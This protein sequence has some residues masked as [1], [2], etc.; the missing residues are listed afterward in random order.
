MFSIFVLGVFFIAALFAGASSAGVTL[1]PRVIGDKYGNDSNDGNEDYVFFG[2]YEHWSGF[3]G[4]AFP[5]DNTYEL[6]ARPILWRVMSADLSSNPRKVI[7]LSH[8]TLDTNKY[9]SGGDSTWL[10]SPMQSFLNSDAS[11]VQT[12][13]RNGADRTPLI[14]GF[15]HESRFSALERSAML[16]PSPDAETNSV[17]TLPSSADVRSGWFESGASGNASRQIGYIGQLSNNVPYWTRSPRVP[18]YAWYV[19][20]DGNLVTYFDVLDA[21]GVRPAFFLNLESL[22]FK[23]GSDLSTPPSG[24]AGEF[25]NPYMLYAASADVPAIS[26]DISV[27]GN[28]LTV[29]F[30]QPVAHAYLDTASADLL[31]AKFT[32]SDDQ[33]QSVA[34]SGVAF[35]SGKLVLTLGKAAAYGGGDFS[36][37]YKAYA[38]TDTDGI[39]LLTDRLAVKSLG[40]GTAQTAVNKTPNPDSGGD[41]DPGMTTVTI[42]GADVASVSVS[43]SGNTVTVGWLEENKPNSTYDLNKNSLTFTYGESRFT[44]ALNADEEL[45]VTGDGV[46]LPDGTI[47]VLTATNT[48]TTQA[49]EVAENSEASLRRGASY[50]LGEAKT[51]VVNGKSVV[52]FPAEQISKLPAGTYDLTF[53][54]KSGANPAFKGTFAKGYVHAVSEPAAPEILLSASETAS[55]G[56]V[57]VSATV[58]SGD[59]PQAGVTVAFTLANRDNTHVVSLTRTTDASGK[60]PAFV[61]DSGLANGTYTVTA[62]ATGYAAVSKSVT[63]SNGSSDP[64]PEEPTGS[65]SSGGCDAGM[66]TGLLLCGAT[67][68]LAVRRKR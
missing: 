2:Q 65:S 34:V 56:G 44:V 54:T 31:A 46:L 36:V 1:T 14:P 6:S 5:G 15:L 41:P 20:S 17:V 53:A 52:T 62:A 30:D 4:G 9:D 51:T 11:T 61:L 43:V 38:D 37:A 13:Y 33:G 67:V 24:E 21:L 12:Y 47:V 60:V 25:L 63:V 7:L 58:T 40:S 59:L 64:G 68:C 45:V 23:S 48:A 19:G 50:S 22:I 55:G 39:G 28:R 27:S 42:D 26:A 32:V 29:S 57:Q 66:S 16:S 49:A 3:V 18:D 35:E 10:G 8:Y